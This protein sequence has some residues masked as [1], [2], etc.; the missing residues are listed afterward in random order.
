MG[1]DLTVNTKVRCLR[2]PGTMEYVGVKKIQFGKTGFFTGTWSNLL[3]GAL[4]VRIS[5]CSNCRKVEFYATEEKDFKQ[6]FPNMLW[7]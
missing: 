4:E 1:E 2:C 6:D 3:S 7:E 5:I